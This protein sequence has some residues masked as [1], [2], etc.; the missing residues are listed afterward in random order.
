MVAL[1][2]FI[3][4]AF[5]LAAPTVSRAEQQDIAA[6]ARGVVRVVLVATDGSEAYFVGHGSGLAVAPDKILTNAHVVELARQCGVGACRQ[7]MVV[8]PVVG[9]EG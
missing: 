4:L 9:Q 8:G 1:F 6:A 7:W 2:R 5:A 3:L